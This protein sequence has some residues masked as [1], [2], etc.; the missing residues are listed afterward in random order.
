MHI[1]CLLKKFV[2]ER[3]NEDAQLRGM[4]DKRKNFIFKMGSLAMFAE[5]R[6]K[7]MLK[8]QEGCG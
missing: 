5:I 6:R 1:D 7:K 4:R 8:N 2:N 3:E